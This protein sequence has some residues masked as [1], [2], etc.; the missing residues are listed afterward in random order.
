MSDEAKAWILDSIREAFTDSITVLIDNRTVNIQMIN[1]QK[2]DQRI[3][4]MN[5]HGVDP[6]SIEN[7]IRENQILKDRVKYLEEEIK[8]LKKAKNVIE[9]DNNT[10]KKI[11]EKLKSTLKRLRDALLSVKRKITAIINDNRQI[12]RKLTEVK[13]LVRHTPPERIEEMLITIIENLKK[14]N[15]ELQNELNKI[16]TLA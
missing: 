14:T 15:D 4:I 9:L 16:N 11:N 3:N 7:L 6:R 2:I 13:S 8:V 10:S 12:I 5:I 1:Q